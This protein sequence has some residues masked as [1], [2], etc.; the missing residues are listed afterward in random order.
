M[1][2]VKMNQSATIIDGWM[3]VWV[4]GRLDGLIDGW[5]NHK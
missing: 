2:G 5:M 4:G 3:H 1:E